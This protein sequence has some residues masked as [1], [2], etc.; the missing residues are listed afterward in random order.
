MSHK[1]QLVESIK[2]TIG[3]GNVTPSKKSQSKKP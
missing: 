3:K 2:H 1:K